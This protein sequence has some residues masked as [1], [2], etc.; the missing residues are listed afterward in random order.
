MVGWNVYRENKEKSK[1]T[2]HSFILA[3]N[4]EPTKR[5][6]HIV[7][8]IFVACI[9]SLIISS[10]RHITHSHSSPGLVTVHHP[11]KRH[12]LFRTW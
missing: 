10:K 8:M 3:D 4:S 7:H 12:V 2:V 6:K 9:V 11:T 5:D 1:L